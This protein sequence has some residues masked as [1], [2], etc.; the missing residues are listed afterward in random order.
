LKSGGSGR[1]LGRRV[2]GS[3]NSSKNGWMQAS[4]C[5]ATTS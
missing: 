5:R 1:P 3:L 2:L 4:N